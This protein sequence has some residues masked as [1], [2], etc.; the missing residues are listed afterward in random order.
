LPFS[1]DGKFL[2]TASDLEPPPAAASDSDDVD[3]NNPWAPFNDR[4]EFEWAEHHFVE[5]ESSM[6][7]IKRGLDL[8]QASI[9][10]EGSLQCV[11]WRNAEELHETRLTID[12]IHVTT[13][14]GT[15]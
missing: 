11:P 1:E 14:D 10:C 5:L 7:K 3:K 9:F 12:S 13:C 6:K 8:W 15:V 2:P 4:V